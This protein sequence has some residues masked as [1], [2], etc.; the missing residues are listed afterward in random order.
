MLDKILLISVS[1]PILIS[2]Q[3]VFS[4]TLV[5][6]CPNGF[7]LKFCTKRETKIRYWKRINRA[8]YTS[9]WILSTCPTGKIELFDRLT[10]SPDTTSNQIR[11]PRK[12]TIYSQSLSQKIIV[13]LA[14]RRWE[15][16]MAD[17]FNQP[18]EKP[19]I[20]PAVA[21]ELTILVNTSITNKNRR[22]EI[23]S[24]WRNPLEA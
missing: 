5:H 12:F 18:K 10:L 3:I 1:L 14:K 4:Q 16:S 20:S 11:M 17:S 6:R 9:N 15:T 23:G 21:A 8:S 13:S 24:P 19:E 2:T 7:I 22:G